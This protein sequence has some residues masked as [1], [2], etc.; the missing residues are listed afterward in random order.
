MEVLVEV[1]PKQKMEKVEKMIEIISPFDGY[2][3]PDAALGEPSVLPSAL[4]VKIRERLGESKRII[5]NQRLADVN[6]LFVRSLAIT[7]KLFSFDVAFTKGD[8]PRFGKE[9]THLTSEKAV[10]IAKGY[11][12][13]S[14]AMM[15]LRKTKEEILRRL[16]TQA[17]FF[18]ALHF[19]SLSSLEGLEKERIIPYIIVKT[20]KNT[21]LIK[22]ISQPSFEER[23]VPLLIQ[24][25][26]VIGV[27]SV[28]LSAPADLDF[29]RKIAKIL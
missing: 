6:E 18:L 28:L 10:E 3:I 5:V 12:V 22:G 26:D 23:E 20:D 14:G 11:G 7:A 19:N 24:D 27:R 25:L 8:K 16:D 9:V 13:R 4:G 2:D 21:E 1:H 17:D 15:S 29:F